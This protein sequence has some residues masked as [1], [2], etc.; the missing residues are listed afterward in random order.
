M[1]KL[2][3]INVLKTPEYV[4]VEKKLS[5]LESLWTIVLLDWHLIHLRLFAIDLYQRLR[6]ILSLL[7]NCSYV[8]YIYHYSDGAAI[9]IDLCHAIV[10]DNVVH[11]KV[12]NV[13]V[14]FYNLH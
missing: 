13:A 10:L 5:F 6:S 8:N 14:E 12:P 2:R 4:G 7:S 3:D 1:L 11:T 9:I